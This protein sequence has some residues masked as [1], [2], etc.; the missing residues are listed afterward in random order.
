MFVLEFFLFIENHFVVGSTSMSA[1][2]DMENTNMRIGHSHVHIVMRLDCMDFFRE[3]NL[4]PLTTLLDENYDLVQ[5]LLPADD[6]LCILV[7]CNFLLDYFTLDVP[8]K[9]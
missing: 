4:P 5:A 6:P 2:M 3:R 8:L 7:C 1:H 9:S